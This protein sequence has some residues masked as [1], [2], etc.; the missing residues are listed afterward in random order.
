MTHLKCCFIQ[1][2]PLLYTQH[3]GSCQ[4]REH[5][6]ATW[7]VTTECSW[8]LNGSRLKLCTKQHCCHGHGGSSSIE[9][10]LYLEFLRA[11]LLG[12]IYYVHLQNIPRGQH[13]LGHLLG[14]ALLTFIFNRFACNKIA[15]KCKIAMYTLEIYCI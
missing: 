14:N 15:L 7:Q 10:F 1:I 2:R 13:L 5:W 3:Y 4:E 9:F 11:L 12:I 8:H 6:H